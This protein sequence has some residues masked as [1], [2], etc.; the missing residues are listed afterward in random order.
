MVAVD[1]DEPLPASVARP[2]GSKVVRP[3][4][5]RL[6][7][8]PPALLDRHRLLALQLADH[9]R[10]ALPAASSGRV[11][12]KDDVGGAGSDAPLLAKLHPRPRSTPDGP[13][14]SWHR[15]CGPGTDPVRSK[16]FYEQRERDPSGVGGAAHLR[17]PTLAGLGHADQ[18]PTC[19]VARPQHVPVRGDE[20]DVDDA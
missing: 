16:C 3:V 11:G 6:E 2:S 1:R 8:S 10:G 19:P 13:C 14:C 12:D 7:P 15:H 17:R 9:E 18:H 5:R 20:A 4:Q